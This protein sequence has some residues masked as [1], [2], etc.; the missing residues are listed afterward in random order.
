VR[1]GDEPDG[2]ADARTRHLGERVGQERMPVAHPDV[3]RQIMSPRAQPRRQTV[4]LCTGEAVSGD[5]P[6]NSS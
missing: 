6:P 4:G 1:G 2:P 3:H 5:T